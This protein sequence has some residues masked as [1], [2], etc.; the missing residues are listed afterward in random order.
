MI[1]RE[2]SH[3]Y[4]LKQ[5]TRLLGIQS[6]WSLTFG[7]ALGASLCTSVSATPLE[8][9]RDAREPGFAQV[10]YDYY[11]N[12][13]YDALTTFLA[14]RQ[15]AFNAP[16]TGDI[17]LSNLYT[18]Y[19]LPRE[20]EASL[21]RAALTDVTSSNRNDPW[22]SYGKLLYQMG[23]DSLALNFLRDP[24][25]LLTPKQESERMI[26]VTNLL[27]RTEHARD[28]IESLQSFRTPI[29]YYRKLARYNLAMSLL[30]PDAVDH[31][32]SQ[33]EQDAQRE[34]YDGRAIRILDD[35][36]QDK[37]PNL[38]MIIKP[39]PV[40]ATASPTGNQNKGGW[41]S[42]FRSK[43]DS[44][45]PLGSLIE[46]REIGN[47]STF[48]VSALSAGD[49]DDPTLTPDDVSKL[50]DKIA[51][52]LA[53]LRL[54]HHDLEQAR[55]ALRGVKLDSLLSNQAL[56]TSAH[57]YYRQGDFVRS[58][59]FANELS[60]RN[61][62]DPLVQEGWLLAARALEDEHDGSAADHY[63]AAI[64]VYKAAT[65]SINQFDRDLDNLDVLATFPVKSADPVLLG[66]PEVPAGTKAGLW[67]GLLERSEVLAIIQQIQQ[68][69]LLQA[70]LKVYDKDLQDLEALKA[71]VN[72]DELDDLKATRVLLDKVKL[73][74][75]KAELQDH[76]ALLAQIR[77]TLKQSRERLD[78]YLT[79][80]LLG[81]QRVNGKR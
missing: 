66:I 13:L 34:E 19:G 80:A 24:P 49:V 17:F 28:A 61:W 67:A 12:H 65:A 15:L 48:T 64:Q 14:N 43:S 40:L 76:K 56:L 74:F 62:A 55:V 25:A 27:T 78:Y 37:V 45:Q 75:Q 33:P 23:Q 54:K 81:L 2:K 71:K 44:S 5:L 4:K 39:K 29:P 57:V 42:W 11:Q 68:T 7:L 69:Q 6:A 3:R 38:V 58:Y 8:V 41:L 77:A 53:Y 9:R 60:K 52:S 79:E 51:L 30:S 16:G 35:L 72:P 63:A 31:L 36:M 32:L 20:A 73:D 47:K 26:M 21:S 1:N 70:K 46:N 50:N 18:R 59:N 10:M 22:L